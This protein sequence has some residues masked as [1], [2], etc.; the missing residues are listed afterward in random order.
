MYL[1]VLCNQVRKC[2]L[3]IQSQIN[4]V[5]NKS[6]GKPRG[7]AFVEFEYDRDMHSKYLA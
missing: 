1:L 6:T 2:C 5:T 4:M 7:Y 3:Y